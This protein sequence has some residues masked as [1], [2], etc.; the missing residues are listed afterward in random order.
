M[1]DHLSLF[2]T[3]A[4]QRY[5]LGEDVFLRT[6]YPMQ[7][8]RFRPNGEIALLSE[9]ALLQQVLEQG[10]SDPGNRLWV[11]YGAP[12]SGKSELIKW[13]ETRIFQES[14]QRSQV[15]VRI[16]RD[17]LD[18]LKIVKR[19]LR[20]LPEDFIDEAVSQRWQTARQKSRTV[21]KLILLFALENLLDSDDSINALFYRLLNVVQPHVDHL[22]NAEAVDNANLSSME[23]IGREA[24]Q[25]VLQETALEIPVEYEQFRHQLTIAFQDH[26]L[27][28]I[29]LPDTMRQIAEYCVRNG[30]QR[31][32]LLVDD[33]VQSLNVFATEILDY[34]LTLEAG[35]WDVVVGL[36]PAA[37]EDNQR[38]REMLQRVTYL[39]T[40]D[41]R[42]EKLWLSDEAGLNSYIVTEDNCYDFA[43]PYLQEYQRRRTGNGKASATFFVNHAV[44]VRIFRNLPSGKGKARYFLR[45]LREILEQIEKGKPALKAVMAFAKTE[46]VVRSDDSTLTALGELYGPLLDTVNNRD[47]ILLTADLLQAFDL[48]GREISLD[49]EPLQK[50]SLPSAAAKHM[51]DDEEKMAIRDWLLARPANRQLVKGVRRGAARWL[52]DVQAIC[53]LHRDHIPKPYGVLRW[54]RKYL[55]TNPPIYLEGIDDVTDAGVMLPREI[56]MVAFDLYQYATAKGRAAKALQEQLGKETVLDAL[57]FNGIAYQA[58]V[59]HELQRQID[60]TLDNLA[61]ALYV[62]RLALEGVPVQR[63]PGFPSEF[64]V[65]L[66][67][68]H[69]RYGWVQNT[70]AEK[71]KVGIDRLFDDFFQLRQNLYDGGRIRHI[72]QHHPPDNLLEQL[73]AI[74]ASALDKDFR[75]ANKPLKEVLVTVQTIIQRCEYG[76]RD[77][78]ELS[79]V[80]QQIVER[81]EDSEP[82][83]FS[84][85]PL[86]TWTELK[87]SR[88]RLFAGL[89]VHLDVDVAENHYSSGRK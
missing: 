80:T 8:R 23:L 79:E 1:N 69:G 13:L 64:W 54:Q 76:G 68:A 29:S 40:I 83:L 65:W 86:A 75:L 71:L 82:V 28:G 27:E 61:L 89:R 49:I 20:L 58:H 21:T 48:P 12:G 57:L 16:S 9:E 31:P 34:L 81:L 17:E 3:T 55:N 41:D 42:V 43:T 56:G 88:P 5:L 18:I 73:L 15:T 70:F 7:L 25:A 39:D 10:R 2:A 67:E 47:Q 87:Q 52:R 11:L 50:L 22:L 4:D 32:V 85:I 46:Y 62:F 14:R 24:W 38:G 26:L 19:F 30:G 51:I 53:R 66:P 72:L 37:F 45:Y 36:T 77:Q 59:V 6:H 33:L 44:L 74:D 84:Q 35:C 78:E 63:L 60:L